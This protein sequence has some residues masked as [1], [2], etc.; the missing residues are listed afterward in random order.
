MYYILFNMYSVLFSPG[1]MHRIRRTSSEW[2]LLWTV[3]FLCSDLPVINSCSSFIYLHVGSLC[4]VVH[5]HIW[6]LSTHGSHL[7]SLMRFDQPFCFT[8]AFRSAILFPWC[9]SISHLVSLVRF[10]QPSCFPRAFWSAILFPLCVLI[11]HFVCDLAERRAQLQ[12][13]RSRSAMPENQDGSRDADGTETPRRPD[14]RKKTRPGTKQ[15]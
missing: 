4:N 12:K 10:D 9:V 11:S 5:A 14:R 1:S 6:P 2:L 3:M 13:S 7:V 8:R 15:P